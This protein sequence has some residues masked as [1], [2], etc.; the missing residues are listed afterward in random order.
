MRYGSFAI[1]PCNMDA[2][3]LSMWMTEILIHT[4]CIVK[5]VLYMPMPRYAGTSEVVKT[6]SRLLPDNSWNHQNRMN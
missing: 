4:K 5:V 1:G 2:T 3:K 6:N